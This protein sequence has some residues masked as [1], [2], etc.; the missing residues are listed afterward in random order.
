MSVAIVAMTANRTETNSDIHVSFM[1]KFP[2][3]N[4]INFLKILQTYE[5]DM[6]TKSIV[7]SSFFWG[8][9]ITQGSFPLRDIYKY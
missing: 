4:R 6:K 2:I 8:Y 5:W 3:K 9:I 7:L 1:I